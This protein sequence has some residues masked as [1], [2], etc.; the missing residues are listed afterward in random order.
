[1]RSSSKKPC[2]KP[3]ELKVLK[4]SRQRRPV[5]PCFV[6]L[7]DH[8]EVLPGYMFINA[9]QTLGDRR[10]KRETCKPQKSLGSLGYD[11]RLRYFWIFLVSLCIQ[12]QFLC[13]GKLYTIFLRLPPKQRQLDVHSRS[14]SNSRKP[15]QPPQ[16]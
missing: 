11:I 10:T 4:I 12:K 13:T 6:F 2:E 15:S 16:L 3:F 14:S 9:Q 7:N 5:N 1:M 8:V